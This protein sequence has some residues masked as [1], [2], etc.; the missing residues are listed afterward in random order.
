MWGN[1]E[2]IRHPNNCGTGLC[3]GDGK[4]QAAQPFLP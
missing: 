3:Y 4:R 1:W 2:D